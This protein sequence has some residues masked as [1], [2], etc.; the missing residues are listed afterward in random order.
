MRG[1]GPAGSPLSLARPSP[2]VRVHG[3][4]TTYASLVRFAALSLIAL[5]A[6]QSSEAPLA[7]DANDTR[8]SVSWADTINYPTMRH[9]M[10]MRWVGQDGGLMAERRQGTVVL[11]DTLRV[12]TSEVVLVPGDST[13]AY[14]TYVAHDSV[15]LRLYLASDPANRSFVQG[16]I[17]PPMIDSRGNRVTL[18]LSGVTQTPGAHGVAVHG[19]VRSLWS[20]GGRTRLVVAMHGWDRGN[21]EAFRKQDAE[22]ARRV[23]RSPA[24]EREALSGSGAALGAMVGGLHG[25]AVGA[26]LGPR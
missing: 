14:V 26:L 17:P 24:P 15:Y 13:R 7:E 8:V 4:M 20:V 25:A 6:C 5:S 11:T 19:T 23:S 10:T 22:D 2:L 1:C 9:P 12:P 18:I 3:V 16:H 21:Q